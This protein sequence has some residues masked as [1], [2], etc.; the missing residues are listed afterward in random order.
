MASSSSDEPVALYDAGVTPESRHSWRDR[1]RRRRLLSIAVGG[2][3]F[4]LLAAALFDLS[5]RPSEQ[6][7]GRKRFW[8]AASFVN[9]VGPLAYFVVGRRRGVKAAWPRR[10]LLYGAGL[11]RQTH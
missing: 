3:Q 5:R 7:R 9:L 1:S 10:V 4:A 6:I 11:V 8:V 2:V